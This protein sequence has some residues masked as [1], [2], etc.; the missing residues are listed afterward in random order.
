MKRRIRPVLKARYKAVFDGIE[1]NVV[2]M[3][4]KVVVAADGVFPVSSLPQS[5]FAIAMT[6][7]AAAGRNHVVAE[8]RLISRHRPE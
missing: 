7:R 4:R 3:A 6:S 2:D 5:E 8:E 1:M